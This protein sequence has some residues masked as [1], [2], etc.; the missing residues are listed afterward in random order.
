MQAVMSKK[1]WLRDPLVIRKQWD[2]EEYKL[3]E[4]GRGRDL[5]FA[6]MWHD[7]VAVPHPPI[8]RALEMVKTALLAQGHKGKMLG[9][10]DHYG[11]TFDLN[12]SYRLEGTLPR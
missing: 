3:V 8:I 12:T 1:P 6:V 10:I 11:I 7:G 2:E 4:H 9:L 5:C